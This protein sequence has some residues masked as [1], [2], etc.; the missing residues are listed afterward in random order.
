[1]HLDCDGNST[2]P[3][4]MFCIVPPYLV[5]CP[6][7]LTLIFILWYLYLPVVF[8]DKYQS[9][10][11]E[12][13][14]KYSR[15]ICYTLPYLCFCVWAPSLIVLELQPIRGKNQYR[16][17]LPYLCFCVWAL[18]GSGEGA[19]SRLS[20][21]CHL[22]SRHSTLNTLSPP[23][24]SSPSWTSATRKSSSTSCRGPARTSPTTATS[25]STTSC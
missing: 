1:M 7:Q 20:P 4:K 5:D 13:E 18:L 22:V 8:H 14:K 6:T 3:R 19:A 9:Y 15:E 17:T 2:Y 24:S 10:K 25:S 23:T 16:P 12:R 11:Y 21:L